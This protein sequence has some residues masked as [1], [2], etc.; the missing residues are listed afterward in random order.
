MPVLAM[1]VTANMSVWLPVCFYAP[2][3]RASPPRGES[4]HPTQAHCPSFTHLHPSA[5]P[6][7]TCRFRLPADSPTVGGVYGGD[8]DGATPKAG[9]GQAE[10]SNQMFRGDGILDSQV[11]AGGQ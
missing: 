9:G 10:F 3:F 8:I 11:G 7:L 1:A 2:L 5:S 4:Q 6:A